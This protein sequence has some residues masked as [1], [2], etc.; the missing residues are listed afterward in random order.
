MVVWCTQNV[1]RDG[2]AAVSRDTG[3][4]TAKHRCKH[5]TSVDIQIA[6][7]IYLEFKKRKRKKKKEKKDSHSFRITRERAQ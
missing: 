7:K 2:R 3:R 5:A 1:R 4:V 6:L